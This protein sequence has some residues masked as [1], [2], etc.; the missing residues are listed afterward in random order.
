MESNTN[1]DWRDGF[2]FVGNHLLLDFLN[3]QPVMNGEAVELL[4]DG[5]ALARWLRATGLINERESAGLARRWATAE[6]GAMIGE[7]REFRE[8]A[9][10]AV[11]N[12]EQG[13][14]VSTSVLKNV[15][16]LLLAYP[17]IDQVVKSGSDLERRRYFAPESPEQAFAPLAD[18]FAD[19][20]T[21]TPASRIRKCNGCV[22]HFY[23][24][25]KKGTRVWC[26]MNLCG[27]RA[28]VA[29]YADRNRAAARKGLRR[30]HKREV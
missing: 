22:L 26:S 10:Q 20:L 25:S 19:L 21:A 15:N 17:H 18:A 3:T 12:L 24:T 23:D 1:D 7:L 13:V 6:C 9:R 11:L 4:P 5:S 27:N 2:L 16:R 30:K 28:K 8:T 14:P 29:A